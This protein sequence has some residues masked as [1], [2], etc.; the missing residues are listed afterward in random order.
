VSSFLGKG[1]GQ[2]AGCPP[3]NSSVKGWEEI[4]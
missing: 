1:S 2:Q 3:M 4:R